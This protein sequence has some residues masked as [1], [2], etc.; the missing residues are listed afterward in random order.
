MKKNSVPQYAFFGSHVFFGLAIVLTGI[1]LA[2][3]GFRRS[4]LEWP[5]WRVELHS[6]QE[7]T[8]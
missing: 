3:V 1:S 5:H 6:P 4:A 7:Q 8:K 2:L